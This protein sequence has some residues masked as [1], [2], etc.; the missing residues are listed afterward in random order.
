MFLSLPGV[1][2]KPLQV[3][4]LSIPSK[5]R[6]LQVFWYSGMGWDPC[7][8]ADEETEVEWSVRKMER[9]DERKVS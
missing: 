2:S 1:M 3:P 4:S 8:S 7:Y 6:I 5:L 9:K